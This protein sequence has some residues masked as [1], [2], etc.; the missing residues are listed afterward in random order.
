MD[1]S[2]VLQE[3]IDGHDRFLNGISLHPHASS[4][5]L[6][7][8]VPGQH[9]YAAI[10][11]CADSRVPVELLFDAGFGDLYI[12]R[13]AGNSATPAS[14]GS[15]DYGVEKLG[16]ELLV[17]MGHQGCGAVTA[18]CNPQE[19]LTPKLAELV[20]SIRQGLDAVGVSNDLEQAFRL[21]PI[22]SARQLVQGS[23]LVRERLDRGQLIVETAYYTLRRGEIEW[24]GQIDSAGQLH[25]SRSEARSL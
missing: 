3:L 22:Q 13:N 2:D 18:A 19:L 14:I 20:L 10:L 6:K 25:P 17:V 16:I 9:P 7:Q 12:V 21:N 11:S 4:E 23:E 5:R 15:L 8:L 1:A 24:L